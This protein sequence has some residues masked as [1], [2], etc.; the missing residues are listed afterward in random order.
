MADG[1]HLEF[2]LPGWGIF[3]L[4]FSIVEIPQSLSWPCD[5]MLL[6]FFV[7]R[8]GTSSSVHSLDVSNPFYR[9]CFSVHKPDEITPISMKPPPKPTDTKQVKSWDL[10]TT[11]SLWRLLQNL[12]TQNR[13]NE[14]CNYLLQLQNLYEALSRAYIHYTNEITGPAATA[15]LW[16]L[17]Q[18]T[19]KWH[20]WDLLLHH[21]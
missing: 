14:T 1:G 17:S 19:K 3:Y 16:S 13:T 2:F 4:D 15:S 11:A 12:Q 5:G 9:F 20:I 8:T 7:S 18:D 6:I 10:L 21:L